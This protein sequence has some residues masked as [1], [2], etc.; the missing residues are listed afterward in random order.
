MSNTELPEIGKISP[1]VFAE[2]IYPRLG[3]QD[4]S[5]IVGPQS[6]VDVGIVR[7]GDQAV[8][9]T[10]DPF[11]IVPQYGWERAA[12]FATHILLSDAVTSGLP[13]R[14]MTIDLNL[15]LSIDREGLDL[16]WGV[17]HRE[18]EKYGVAIVTGHTARYEGCEYP[19]VG[20]ATIISVGPEDSYVTPRLARPGDAII[21][22]KG[23]AIETTGLFVAAL[24]GMIQRRLGA[25]FLARAEDVFW[26]MSV[27]DDARI[28]VAQGVR[29][30]GV[31]CMHDA[32]ECGIYG[33]LWEIADAAG[34][35][36]VVDRDA[37]V[38]VP[39]CMEL[40]AELELDPYACIS[41]G[42]L[43]LTCKPHAADAIVS[44]LQGE[45][46]PASVCGEMRESAEGIHIIEGGVERPLEH[47]TVDPF[48]AAFGRALAEEAE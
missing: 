5:V 10:T 28:A 20:G 35:G 25:D 7:I 46:I 42:T 12:W 18:C 43:V 37:I 1:E 30:E 26:M 11:F 31:T 36:L 16:M 9:M 48:W 44:A 13:P 41:E 3:A 17:I 45:G 6:G 8:A 24:P 2:M 38:T 47:T 14:Y 40:C 27:V 32:T 23:P 34:L 15:P 19:M 22:T 39:E 29:E 4:D 21:I 33:A